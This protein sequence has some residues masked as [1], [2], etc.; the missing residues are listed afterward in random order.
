MKK[1]D[2]YIIKKFLGT[3]I[4]VLFLIMTIAIVFD[5]SERME[6]FLK[7]KP[8]LKAI[9][10]DYYQN[11]FYFWSNQFSFLIIFIAVI[12]FTSKLAQNSEVIAILS[13]G[14]SFPRFLRP[15]LV[16][17]TLLTA[18]SLYTNHFVL[19]KANKT[20]KEFEARYVWNKMTYTRVHR[21]MDKGLYAFINSYY[22]GKVDFMWIEKWEG[23]KLQSVFYA[24]RAYCDSLSKDW[25]FEDY[26]QRRIYDNHEEIRSGAKLDTTL[27]FSISD[28]GMR[29]EWATTM[30]SFELSDYIRKEKE[31][32]N[33][34][35]ISYE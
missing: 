15:Y 6:E 20:L 33:E 19:P 5:I 26:F 16:T 27:G 9:I 11:F 2:W 18:V 3:F 1:L 17:A 12:F 8:P 35:I 23:P 24:S 14:V 30:S 34:E 4:F 21:E 22:D 13:S 31:R 10:F 28:F 32:G 25:R 29:T 7:T